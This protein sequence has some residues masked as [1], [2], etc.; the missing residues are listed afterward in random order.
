LTLYECA[1]CHAIYLDPQ[2]DGMAYFHVCGDVPNPALQPD[3]RK[4]AY[5]PRQFVPMPGK[6]DE[7]IVVAYDTKERDYMN[8]Q[9]VTI[10]DKDAGRVKVAV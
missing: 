1:T 10:P 3:P 8:V 5:D 7:N 6:R 2:A 4:P 9:R